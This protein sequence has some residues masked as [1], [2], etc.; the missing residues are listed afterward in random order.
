MV[1]SNNGTIGKSTIAREV[2]AS[3]L[4]EYTFL[5]IEGSQKGNGRYELPNELISFEI[6]E[7][8]DGKETVGEDIAKTI[9]LEDDLIIDIGNSES[10][11]FFSGALGGISEVLDYIDYFLIVTND[12]PTVQQNTVTSVT[13]LIKAFC[14]PSE[15]IKI[16]FNNFKP[17]QKIVNFYKSFILELEDQK[18]QHG[19]EIDTQRIISDNLVFPENRQLKVLNNLDTTLDSVFDGR[20]WKAE[21]LK[22]K[23]EGDKDKERECVEHEITVMKCRSL[24]PF[25]EHIVQHLV[26]EAAPKKAK[27]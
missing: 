22:A 27:K 3:G 24:L 21:R 16:V 14:V 1:L 4:P 12:N 23:A 15:K 9:L 19:Y 10:K 13:M 25:R 17:G 26:P 11:A 18:N 20:D 5:E 2:L 7:D 6:P 8:D